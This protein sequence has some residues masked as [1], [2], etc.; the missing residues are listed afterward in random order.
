MIRSHAL[1][2]TLTPSLADQE[3]HSRQGI[4]AVYREGA[5]TAEGK[6]KDKKITGKGYVEL[7]GYDR[8]FDAPL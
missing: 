7:T 6:K 4:D 8:P 2:L 3:A 5:I 1:E